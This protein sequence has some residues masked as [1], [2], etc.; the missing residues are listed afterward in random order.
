MDGAGALPAA[1]TPGPAAVASSPQAN[2]AD[3]RL[4]ASDADPAAPTAARGTADA[5]G[6]PPAEAKRADRPAT[7]AERPAP[8]QRE[9]VA[10]DVAAAPRGDSAE[11]RRLAERERAAGFA[12]GIES[13]AAQRKAADPVAP[14]P[15]LQGRQAAGAQ[16]LAPTTGQAGMARAE[17]MAVRPGVTGTAPSFPSGC[18][19]LRAPGP[20][21]ASLP[22]VP[23][24]VRL[25]A[26]AGPTSPPDS[27]WRAAVSLDDPAVRL[28]LA[29]RM[30]DSLTVE[31]RV[32]RSMD[33]TMVRFRPL[34]PA[35]PAGLAPEGVQVAEARRIACP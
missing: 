11:S 20:G 13:R 26:P 35:P 25:L 17:E 10:R 21:D 24:R 3:A 34:E 28:V 15:E 8:E 9:T 5:A 14:L 30:A 16:A 27:A 18:Y 33:S 32:L 1:A 22:G 4:R 19:E 7:P 31:L 29:W 2:E 12:A 6:E 23:G